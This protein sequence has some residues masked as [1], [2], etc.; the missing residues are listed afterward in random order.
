MTVNGTTN[1]G[2]TPPVGGA[3]TSLER[4]GLNSDTFLKLLVAQLKYQDPTKP[5]DSASMLQQS[6]QYTM[7]EKLNEVSQ[8]TQALLAAQQMSTATG[9]LGRTITA[10]LADKTTVT[11]LVSAVRLTATGPMVVVN[12]REI[13]YASVQTVTEA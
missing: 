12:D 6:S 10:T 7:V 4:S 5:T 2:T 1:Q 3:S 13:P 8:G 11:G 9:Y